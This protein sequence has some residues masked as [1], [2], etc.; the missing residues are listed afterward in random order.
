MAYLYRHIRLDLNTPFYIGIGSDDKTQKRSEYKC[1][2]NAW[3]NVINK[4]EYR[5]EIMLE[6]LTWEEACE[7]EREFIALYGRRDLGKGPLVNLTDGGEG[8]FGYR[9]TPEQIKKGIETRRRNGTL[10]HSVETKRKIGLKA[11]GRTLSKEGREK[12]RQFHLGKPKTDD[13]KQKLRGPKSE[14]HKQKIRQTNLNKKQLIV[15]CP[16]C[17]KEGGHCSAMTRWHF[18]NCKNKKG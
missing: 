10:N 3:K 14:D 5:V 1:R 15:V 9:H 11:E 8:G 18:D 16:H 2:S 4:T 13:H 7:K 12:I 6:D 17:Y